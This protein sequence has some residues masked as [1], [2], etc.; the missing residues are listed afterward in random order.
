MLRVGAAYP[1]L[2]V[3]SSP[4]VQYQMFHVKGLC[5]A[6]Y[7]CNLQVSV[8]AQC[9]SGTALLI[10]QV[11]PGYFDPSIMGQ[12]IAEYYNAAGDSGLG[13]YPFTMP[14]WHK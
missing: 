1:T 6:V 3:D 2:Y 4:P 9:F 5:N 13:F 7:W 14:A 11:S 8:G 12:N 10:R